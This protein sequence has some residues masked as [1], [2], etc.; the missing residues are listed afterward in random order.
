MLRCVRIVRTVLILAALV[1][2]LSGWAA[3]DPSTDP[4]APK[5]E[6]NAW[7]K[8][9]AFGFNMTSGNSET[10]LLTGAFG[11]RRESADSIIDVALSAGYGTDSTRTAPG[12]DTTTRNEVRGNAGYRNF[13]SDSWYA[14]VGVAGLHDNIA[15]ID[16]RFTLNPLLGA[17][18]VKNAD[19]SYSLEAGPSYI[20]EEV[21]NEENDYFA[22]RVAHRFEW[23][24][25]CTSKI[26]HG[27]EALF[28][29]DDSENTL[30]N[31]DVNVEAAI[32]T[33]LAM[34]FTVRESFD[35]VPAAGR[36]RT[37]VQ[38]ITALKVS[39]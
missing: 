23:I 12:D 29:V 38:V 31:A 15:D 5:K 22:P 1:A 8:S 39:L 21:G 35:N 13:L 18:L 4:C 27:A 24:L 17:F 6:L 11:A 34:V 26:T 25:S 30:V 37:D 3:C 19:V 7:T 32:A 16:Y 2:P 14:G 9:L 10:S 36:E 28:D 33:N 20:A